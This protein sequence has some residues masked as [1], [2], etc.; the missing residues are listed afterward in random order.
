MLF[1]DK[2]K[3]QTA[4]RWNRF[5]YLNYYVRDENGQYI[6]QGKYYSCSAD[7][8]MR[9]KI[10]TALML[11]WGI[12]A[13]CFIGCGFLPQ[14]IFG[15]V[16]YVI[17]AYA[18]ELAV[19]LFALYRQIKLIRFKDPVKEYEYK[20]TV[21]KLS[22][23]YVLGVISGIITLI[24]EACYLFFVWK[25]NF[26]YGA[27]ALIMQLLFTV[28]YILLAVVFKKLTFEEV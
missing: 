9:R 12:S 3:K 27:A 2:Q 24:A 19:I 20:E 28:S 5:S 14:K 16:F 4:D 10:H 22:T 18:A 13:A 6:Y 15:A 26:A 21:E 11:L 23:I 8:S 7:A 17:L 1:P 25:H